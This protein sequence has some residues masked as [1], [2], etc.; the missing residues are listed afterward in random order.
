MLPGSSFSPLDFLV[1]K[2]IYDP[3]TDLYS[4]EW[5]AK[6]YVLVMDELNTGKC[7]WYKQIIVAKNVSGKILNQWLH[8][9]GQYFADTFAPI[10]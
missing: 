9:Y 1:P 2:E 7:G 5:G 4:F 8:E 10:Y 3:N 6:L